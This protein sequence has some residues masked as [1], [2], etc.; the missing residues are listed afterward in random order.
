MVS[1]I[2]ANI[3]LHYVLDDWFVKVVRPRMK[4][5][6]FLIRF[7]DD[8]VI[9]CTLESDARR[10][11]EVLPKRLGR[12][13]LT[14]HPEKSK[15]ISFGKPLEMK[16]EGMVG[17]AHSIFSDS[18]ATGRGHGKGTGSSSGK[19]L[20]NA[21][22]ERRKLL[23]IWCRRNRHLSIPEQHHQL[24]PKLKGHFLYYYIRGNFDQLELFRR[25][26]EKAWR[27]WL[28]RRSQR[29]LLTWPKFVRLLK[30]FPLPR[31]ERVYWI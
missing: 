26:V 18:L 12:F 23:W 21:S 7:A 2:L 4:G 13:G 20:E 9:G 31:P 27:F 3:F 6:C 28:S 30:E 22:A 25:F 29:G 1:P 11:M 8:F 10:I 17:A 14:I 5:K 19:R 24:S 15:L 16:R